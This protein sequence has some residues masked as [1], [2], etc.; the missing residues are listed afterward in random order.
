MVG[1]TELAIEQ[2]VACGFDRDQAR[3][4]LGPLMRE[5]LERIMERDTMEA[6]TGPAERADTD[7][8]RRHMEVLS[9]DDR[10]IYRLLTRKIVGIA[11]QKNTGRDYGELEACLDQ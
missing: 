2:L 6:L 1:L 11:K 8:V 9:G 7:T 3:C 5:N 4:A 10:E